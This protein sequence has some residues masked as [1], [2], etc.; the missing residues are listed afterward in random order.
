VCSN[1]NPAYTSTITVSSND[2]TTIIIENFS[3]L[4]ASVFVTATVVVTPNIGGNLV[5][6]TIPSQT[7][8]YYT[9][10]GSGTL[11]LDGQTLTITYT[12]D[13]LTS[14]TCTGTWVKQ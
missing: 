6:I 4:G 11:S 2:G 7:V 12:I 9:V 14:D 8:D 3:G 10:S 1:G 13:S 5:S